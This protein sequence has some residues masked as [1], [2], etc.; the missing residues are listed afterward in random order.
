MMERTLK[1]CPFCGGVA[2]GTFMRGEYGP[3]AIAKCQICGCQTRPIKLNENDLTMYYSVK[4]EEDLEKIIPN[5]QSV[6]T[7]KSIW[8]HRAMI[9]DSREAIWNQAFSE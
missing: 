2:K 6:Q 3:F 1:P 5:L 8:N 9:P 7:V 4:G